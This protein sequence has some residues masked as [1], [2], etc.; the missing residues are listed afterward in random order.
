MKSKIFALL[1]LLGLLIGS[2]NV[3]AANYAGDYRYW[4]QGGSDYLGMRQVGCLITA[5]AKMIYEANIDRGG[6]FNP[7]WWYNWLLANGGIASS[8]N[9]NMRDHASPV[10][11]AR[12]RGKNLEYLGYW[13]AD[14][15]QLW[16]NINAGYYT[17]VHV[18]GTNTGGSHFVLLDNAYSKQ[19]G[20]LYCYDSFSDRGSVGRQLLT[21][22]SI[23]NGGHVYKGSNPDHVHSYSSSVSKQPTCT[24]A[25]VKNYVCACGASYTEAIAA[26]GHSYK[27]QTVA[28]TMTEKGYTLHTCVACNNSYKDNYVDP[29]KEEADGWHYCTKL[30][31]GI[32]LNKYVVQYQNYYEKVQQN[33]PGAGWISAG[34]V[35][36]EWQDVGGTYTSATDLPTSNERVL[37]HSVFY[38]FCGPNAG[39]E[40]NYEQ[41]G[42]FVH[43]D[44]I[45]ASKVVSKYLGT[46]NGYP[47]YYIYWYNGG[48]RIWCKSGVSCDGK[49]G[50]HK[51]RCCAWYKTNVYQ[52]RVR[53]QHYKFTKTSDWTTAKDPAAASARIRFK[54]AQ[55]EEPKPE[56]PVEPEKPTEPTNPAEPEKPSEPEKPTEPTNPVE[57]EKPS[58]PTKP[59]EPAKPAEPTAPA[60][61]AS[62][63]PRK[64]ITVTVS[65][66]QYKVTKS[67]KTQKEVTFTGL[68]NKR[69]ASFSIPATVKIQG[70]AYKV[71]AVADKAFRQNKALKSVTVGKNITKLGTECFFGCANLKKITIQSAGLKSVGRNAIKG[72][73]KKTVIKCP[74][75]QLSKYKKLFNG[76]AGYVKTMK[77]NA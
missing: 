13:R 39:K 8:S 36:D 54:S 2:Q 77:V 31:E 7:D 27:T 68:K 70:M 20:T 14:D 29:P 57:P 10:Y 34:V 1:L 59:S 40:G 41:T 25:G 11:Y 48:E 76:A 16:Y 22:Y 45:N 24:Q 49:W 4:S 53:V 72:I 75:K 50:T 15:A 67:T 63:L 38:H 42:K 35:K 18:S 51:T 58:D 62:V 47:Y 17:I 66:G 3:M 30:P 23:H 52:N 33:S 12:S 73:Y 65:N 71:T 43:Y 26:K 44:E 6:Y 5:Q 55:T 9:L 56:K 46:D 60:K 69:Q 21:R 64:G 28:P 19:T 61:P 32:D 37:V 74:K